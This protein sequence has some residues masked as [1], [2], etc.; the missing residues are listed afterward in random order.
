[1]TS[2]YHKLL[3]SYSA[4]VRTVGHVDTVAAALRTRSKVL[5]DVVAYAATH[6]GYCVED[7]RTLFVQGKLPTIDFK[8]LWFAGLGRAIALQASQESDLKRREEG[9]QL[10]LACLE[11][12]NQLFPTDNA[13]QQFH[14]LQ[15][16]L[17]AAHGQRDEAVRL[18]ENNDFLRDFYY[19]YL[20]ADLDNPVISGKVETYSSWLTGFNRPFIA[21]SLL[22]IRMRKDG[23]HSFDNIGAED[24]ELYRGG[25]KVSVIMTS[26]KPDC[27]AFLVAVQSILKQ[28][29][30][31]IELII[32]DDASPREFKGVLTKAKNLDSRVKLIELPV[33]GGTYRARNAGIEL[34]TGEFITGQDSD[35]WSHPERIAHE[36]GY[37]LA[38]PASTGVAVEA[39]RVDNDLVRMFPGRIPHRLCEVSLM[40]KTDLAREVGGY[41]DARKGADSEFRR[42]VEKFTGKN[43]HGIYKP[44]YLIRIG[45]ES[46]SDGDFKP[47]WSH[48]VRR[49]FWNASQHWHENTVSAEMRITDLKGLP[50]PVP[51]RFKITEPADLPNFDAVFVGDWRAYGGTQ[52]AM[53][54]GICAL[55]NSGQRVG[56]MHLETPLSPS[57]E[58]TRLADELQTLINDGEVEEIIPDESATAEVVLVQDPTVLQFSPQYAANLVSQVTLISTDLPPPSETT[59]DTWYLPETCNRVAQEMFTGRVLWTS[60]D[61]A[62]LRQLDQSSF[63]INICPVKM[64]V[65]FQS[66]NWM[67]SRVR[68]KDA[69]PVVGRHAI[70]QNSQWP[71][72]L[73][74][75]DCLW[76]AD[77]DLEVRILGDA[78]SYLRKYH[79]RRYPLSWVV[80]RDKDVR[81]EAFMRSIDFFIFFPDEEHT[82]SY[83]RQA[84]EAASSGALV[85]L[86][87]SF[88][89]SHKGSAIYAD[90]CEVPDVVRAYAA[91]PDQYRLMVQECTG[92]LKQIYD[93][94]AYVEFVQDLT[95]A[96]ART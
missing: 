87:P 11:I 12:A 63:R 16:E 20:K 58:T 17:L 30:Q 10:G 82:Q 72:E 62:V 39:I 32:V 86:P 96:F 14:R 26:Y 28:S 45:H 75:S 55:V 90:V 74:S 33:N 59:P 78:R 13:H 93:N 53:I 84:V 22:P 67:N 92:Q 57:K 66:K 42:R 52:R 69:K 5:C 73:S 95:S 31:N 80:F 77:A 83:C 19:G 50:L 8:P 81:P 47:G 76:P 29:W 24:V 3:Q 61:P 85:I 34:A 2:G 1:M 91:E 36:V 68:L 7:L 9:L 71:N 27:E 49:A 94:G 18:V 51:N 46:L 54:D 37:M 60:M 41:L 21:N 70:N 15:I 25:P 64:P 40:L 88:E 56:V 43:I 38:N 23:S 44:L 35:D 4:Y 79:A 89:E 65:P 6:D 48:P